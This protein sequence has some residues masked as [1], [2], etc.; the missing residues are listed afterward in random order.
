MRHAPTHARAAIGWTDL[1]A[2]LSGA[3]ALDALA[4]AL[5]DAPVLSSDLRRARETADRLAGRRLRLPDDPALRELHFGD[6][7]GL[8]FDVIAARWPAEARAFFETPGPA[9]PPGGESFDA[10]RAR[11]GRAVRGH[12]G[13]GDAVIAVAHAGAIQAALAEAGGLT[14]AQALRF[15]IAPLSVT[16][17]DWLPDARAW[18]I[19]CVNV[20]P[21]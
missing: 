9:A 11:V 8:D 14:A 3:E 19:G 6:W 13:P 20:R 18:R 15:V 1:P 4:A 10:L 16:R 21:G 17:L 2:D 7:E 12:R 5:P